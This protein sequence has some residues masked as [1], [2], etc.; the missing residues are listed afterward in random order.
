M[1]QYASKTPKEVMFSVTEE[2]VKRACKLSRKYKRSVLLHKSSAHAGV[3]VLEMNPNDLQGREKF[4]EFMTPIKR[5]YTFSGLG[6]PEEKNAIN[7]R[8]LNLPLG[9]RT[10]LWLAMIVTQFWRGVPGKNR[11]LRRMG[12]RIGS[13]TEIMQFVWLDHFRPELVFIGDETLIGAYSR[14]AV[15][16]Y[17]GRGKFTYALTVI[18]SRC[19]I[20][21]GS[22]LGAIVIE[23]D[24]R[25][26]QNTTVSPYLGRIKKGSVV[27]WNPPTVT[28]D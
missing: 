21:A 17:D 20:G 14:V 23:D 25:I 18:G 12:Y 22:T 26:L 3:N 5:H 6:S 16:S 19:L 9:R 13:N 15:H 7:W 24:V 28:R 27:G 4:I 11:F 1:N 8:K 10:R 2:M